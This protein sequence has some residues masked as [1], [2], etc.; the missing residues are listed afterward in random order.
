[1]KISSY[2][3]GY[4]NFLLV[5]L[6]AFFYNLLTDRLVLLILFSILLGL[7]SFF[8]GHELDKIY[9]KSIYCIKTKLYNTNFFYERL[10]IEFE[11]LK[12]DNIA[13][14]FCFLDIF[15]F[16]QL[17]YFYANRIIEKFSLVLNNNKSQ[18]GFI[19]YFGVGRFLLVLPDY[20]KL[21]AKV[22][23]ERIITQFS[24]KTSYNLVFNYSIS[25][26]PDDG[27]SLEELINLANDKKKFV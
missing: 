10:P 16:K 13:T 5:I 18:R 27:I 2:A 21:G 1:M 19:I 17:D 23:I 12:K 26:F 11:L 14:V 6:F 7:F 9:Y 15:D 20:N 4:I 25:L 22:L 8:L 24:L 3:F